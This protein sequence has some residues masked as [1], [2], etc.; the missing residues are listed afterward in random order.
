MT[1][2]KSHRSNRSHVGTS[3]RRTSKKK[4]SQVASHRSHVRGRS[5]VAGRKS[6]VARPRLINCSARN[7]H[8][9]HT[10]AFMPFRLA[11]DS[12]LFPQMAYTWDVGR[13]TSPR[14]AT[15]DLRP[16]TSFF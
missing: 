10:L 16:A 2:R 11:T 1:I 5:Q 8:L 12:H 14:R 15:C 6:Q 3:E 13:A 4:K 9:A 7:P